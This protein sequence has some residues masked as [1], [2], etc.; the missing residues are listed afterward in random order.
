MTLP[1][2][3]P[4]TPPANWPCPPLVG[5]ECGLKQATEPWNPRA[6]GLP[7][8]VSCHRLLLENL[9]CCKKSAPKDPPGEE[10]TSV[11][12]SCTI[13]C[14]TRHSQSPVLVPSPSTLPLLSATHTHTHNTLAHSHSHTLMHS[15]TL[16]HTRC[17]THFPT[18][19][20]TF[21]HTP[22]HPRTQKAPRLSLSFENSMLQAGTGSAVCD[23]L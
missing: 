6:M 2:H 5:S 15:H 20:C 7:Q 4:A 18:R 14:P 1:G 8:N 21:S 22:P 11:C 16:I 13:M 23:V 12:C 9:E 3:P 10:G 19:S 17:H